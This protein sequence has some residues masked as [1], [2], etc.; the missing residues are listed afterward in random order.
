MRKIFWTTSITIF[1]CTI[2]SIPHVIHAQEQKGTI[3]GTV[4]RDI[5]ANGVCVNE[6]EPRVAANIPMELV[7]DD[8]G[9]L[10]R[11]TT[12]ADGSYIS[13]RWKSC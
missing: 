5:N 1:L 11:L 13:N 4:Y 7:L 12:V 8:V 6:G 2:L 9:E 3:S 10:V